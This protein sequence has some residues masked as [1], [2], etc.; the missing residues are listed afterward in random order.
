LKAAIQP[1]LD[2]A[3]LPHKSPPDLF[4]LR[5]GESDFDMGATVSGRGMRM[6]TGDYVPN[7]ELGMSPKDLGLTLDISGTLRV[8]EN[9]P[10]ALDDPEKD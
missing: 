3:T 5:L 6:A 4:A 10:L 7:F 9:A 1:L 8:T 2:I